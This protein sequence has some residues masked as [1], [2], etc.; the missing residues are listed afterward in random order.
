MPAGVKE[1]VSDQELAPFI[2][3]YFGKKIHISSGPFNWF[4]G[5]GRKDK[6]LIYLKAIFLVICQICNLKQH[7][8]LHTLFC[9]LLQM[10]LPG[11]KV[12]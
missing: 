5:A 7:G 9:S 4:C 3:L 6:L 2:M 1:R 12:S 10:P 8:V 11:A